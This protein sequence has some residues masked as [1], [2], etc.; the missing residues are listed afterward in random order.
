[1][2]FVLVA[3]TLL[4][5]M[6]TAGAD[7]G[8][9]PFPGVDPE[10]LPPRLALV[11][12]VQRYQDAGSVQ[13][14]NLDDTAD[15]V[16]TMVDL[17]KKL[18]FKTEFVTGT[19][20]RPVV[21][22]SDIQRAINDFKNRAIAARQKANRNP[23][24]L[25][26][27][28][29]HGFNIDGKNF[30]LPSN[31]YADDVEDV[32]G[33]ALN[34][35][36]DVVAKLSSAE[37]AL[38]IIVTDSCR[39]PAPPQLKRRG[40]NEIVTAAAN[41]M[42]EPNKSRKAPLREDFGKNQAIFL[43]S[44][45]DQQA[46]FG[47][48]AGGRFTRALNKAFTDALNEARNDVPS[49]RSLHDIFIRARFGM[50]QLTEKW[51]RPQMDE[52]WGTS[53]YPLPTENDFKRE[54][55]TFA[56]SQ[57]VAPADYDL[58]RD[59]CICNMRN[60]LFA[61]SEFSYFSWKVIQE[62]GSRPSY[63]PPLDCEE[64]L[65]LGGGVNGI[66]TP[67]LR[68]PDGRL[69]VGGIIGSAK[70]P[71]GPSSTPQA[72]SLPRANPPAPPIPRAQPSRS[73]WRPAGPP[74]SLAGRVLTE[75]PTKARIRL[76][77][78][79]DKPEVSN[80]SDAADPVDASAAETRP[81]DN[82]RSHVEAKPTFGDAEQAS[83]KTGGAPPPDLQLDPTV[84]LDKAVVAKQNV[85][86]RST[87]ASSAPALGVVQAGQLLEVI[88]TS[89]DRAWIE[90]RVNRSVTGFVSGDYVEAALV[91]LSKAV[92]F[93]TQEFELSEKAK[94]E[95][96]AS[97][98][99]LGGVLVVD[100]AVDYPTSEASIGFARAT[101]TSQ[102]IQNLTLPSA[103]P[104]ASRLLVSVRPVAPDKIEPN[105]VRATIL[106]LPLDRKT[107]TAL[108]QVSRSGQPIV[109]DLNASAV[110]KAA[111]SAGEA[112]PDLKFCNLTGADCKASG[113]PK[114]DL[115]TV[116]KAV[117]ENTKDAQIKSAP[118]TDVVKQVQ[119]LIKF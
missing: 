28:A 97:F 3:L 105:T 38:Q 46:A 80:S 110:A 22:K 90:V 4:G 15:D 11:V 87:S 58:M 66:A 6:G 64:V 72:P 10:V 26:Y 108:A 82:A 53:F 74:V 27:F 13:I 73:L 43:F 100:A 9:V 69:D 42:Y 113:T 107:R 50:A 76:A 114:G 56:N 99:A 35:L 106:C 89:Q 54:Q 84:P 14:T 59:R 65:S 49:N 21:E 61:F 32:D 52:S 47:G 23:I 12:G 48:G 7:P 103:A 29:G 116:L 25:F 93:D 40:T 67:A 71:P 51:Q 81:G 78:V 91:K 57:R 109:M 41:G 24:L 55:A 17:F 31:F 34:V 5:L 86:L 96:A 98:G 39:S 88:G 1:M 77:Q 101:F 79:A 62:I 36:T 45:L 117:R 111:A 33:N 102:F 30:L 94:A 95:L 85:F 68:G 44:S 20:N 63:R 70:E 8:I 18:G 60:M 118:V 104:N 19:A 112:L 75:R 83:R 115:N 37:P 119:G 92:S 16:Q 2:R